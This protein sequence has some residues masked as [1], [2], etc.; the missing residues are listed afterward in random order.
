MQ[1]LGINQALT[2]EESIDLGLTRVDKGALTKNE[3]E[4]LS[5]LSASVPSKRASEFRELLDNWAATWS[6]TPTRYSSHT[7]DYAQTPE[8]DAFIA[9]CRGEGKTVWPLIISAFADD[10]SI[11]LVNALED[12]IG[13]DRSGAVERADESAGANRYDEDGTLIVSTLRGKWMAFCKKIL[14]DDFE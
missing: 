9:F 1:A 12:A 5:Q 10:G 3:K 8:Y 11:F 7:R 2:F 14:E 6:Q 4:K 13:Q